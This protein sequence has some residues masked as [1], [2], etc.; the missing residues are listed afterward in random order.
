MSYNNYDH[1]GVPFMGQQPYHPQG[2]N[3]PQNKPQF[4]KVVLNIPKL[5]KEIL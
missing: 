5:Q 4:K 1:N 2:G 3:Y